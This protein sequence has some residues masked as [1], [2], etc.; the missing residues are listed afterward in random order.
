MKDFGGTDTIVAII[1][2]PGMGAV[3]VIRLSGT[4]A[5][6]IASR[7]FHPK[8]GHSADNL[9]THMLHLGYI[10]EDEK[11]VDEAL[12]AIMRRPHSYTGEDVVEIS[13]HGSEFIQQKILSLCMKEGARQAGPGEFTLRAFLNG[14]MDLSQ[15]EAVAD[16]IAADSA[17]S[18]GLALKQ[19]RGGYSEE[20]REL[21][22]QLLQF[23]SL[24]ELEL[25]FSE[26]DVEFA[27]RDELK[28]VV[29]KI[30]GVI[31]RL[32]DSFELGNAIRKGIPV[33]IAGKPNAGKSTLLNALLK[34]DRAIVSETPGTTRDTIEEEIT[35]GG[36]KFRL[37]DT[38]GLRET[39]DAI[40][41]TGVSKAL[42]KMDESA[43]ILYL[44]DVTTTTPESLRNEI[45]TLRKKLPEKT[46]MLPVGNKTDKV[47]LKNVQDEFKGMDIHW[48]SAM[49]G[50]NLESLSSHLLSL[51]GHGKISADQSV[52]T[53]VRHAGA[54]RRTA[55]SL[56]R[57]KE[58][59]TNNLT[60]DLIAADLRHALSSLGEITG[61]IT[62]EDL[63]ENIFGK[64]C[65]GK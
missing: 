60:N 16:L 39:E 3:A 18:H 37:I 55:E 53:N 1:T 9:H 23:A 27:S 4:Q 42:Q 54:L 41:R 13:C 11:V 36:V 56:Q 44:F 10:V 63:L 62:T 21:R 50:D 34:E 49:T 59:L 48:I 5:T 46:L 35:L 15:A 6:A 57:V 58:G 2:P 31:T 61:E 25:D 28:K 7:I 17:A 40:E 65:I 14:R 19:M 32:I 38:A 24:I 8:K 51:Y 47:Y 45:E 22:H 12:L 52:V 64:F 20:I 33:V 30:L 29:E 26:E 43:I